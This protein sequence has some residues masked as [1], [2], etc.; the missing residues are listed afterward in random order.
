MPHI[1][2]DHL[3]S[4]F[5]PLSFDTLNKSR[6]PLPTKAPLKLLESG[7]I[8]NEMKIMITDSKSRMVVIAI[9]AALF[10]IVFYSL[11]YSNFRPYSFNWLSNTSEG[12][13]ESKS[14]PLAFFG[15][16]MT[17]LI[18]ADLVKIISTLSIPNATPLC[19][20]KP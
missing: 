18:D 17:S 14:N 12:E 13:A 19:G 16:A 11:Y 20:G 7:D 10:I 9:T 1:N 3:S 15:K 6:S 5:T 2:I 8:K 4:F